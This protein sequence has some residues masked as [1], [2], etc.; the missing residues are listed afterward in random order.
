MLMRPFSYSTLMIQR[1]NHA[2]GADS[3][4][5]LV[6]HDHVAAGTMKKKT[7]ANDD[8]RARRDGGSAVKKKR[9]MNAVLHTTK[10][11]MQIGEDHQ[12]LARDLKRQRRQISEGRRLLARDLKRGSCLKKESRVSRRQ[13]VLHQNWQAS[14]EHAWPEFLQNNMRLVGQSQTS[15]P[16]N[17]ASGQSDV[18]HQASPRTREIMQ[19]HAVSPLQ[20][21]PSLP[22]HG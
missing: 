3:S 14:L 17:Q 7:S 9:T 20:N 5:L 6:P 18:Y 21:E 4:D 1:K 10:Q 11:M 12:L 13:S 15:R 8:V 22:R 16:Q 2:A 19:L